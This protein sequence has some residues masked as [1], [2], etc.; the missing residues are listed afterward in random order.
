MMIGDMKQ[1]NCDCWDEMNKLLKSLKTLSPDAGIKTSM[2]NIIR[3]IDTMMDCDHI[4]LNLYDRVSRQFKPIAWR[5]TL[6]P[7]DVPLEQKFMGER[8]A[9]HEPVII[10]DLSP[11]NYRL[12]PA[13]ARLGLQSMVGVPILA[14]KKV[15]GTI[16]VFSR[17]PAHFREVEAELLAVY[18][19]SASLVIERAAKGD[20]IRWLSAENSLLRL[21]LQA[22]KISTVSLLYEL[23]DLFKTTV[24]ADGVLALGVEDSAGKIG[25]QEVMSHNFPDKAATRLKT[26]FNEDFLAKLVQIPDESPERY[27]IRHSPGNLGVS[28]TNAIFIIPVVWQRVLYG[29]IIFY[30]KQTAEE[31]GPERLETFVKQITEYIGLA[32]SRK[33]AYSNMQRISLT[34]NLT[35][36][37]N[38][39][40]FDY[41][42]E[43]EFKRVKR[44]G[45]SLSLLLIDID[46]F[47]NINDC[48]G[49]TAGDFI[50]EQISALLMSSIRG[51][52]IAARYGGE[53]LAVILPETERNDAMMIA[54]RFREAVTATEFVFHNQVLRITVSVG[55]AT[56]DDKTAQE[57]STANILVLAADQAL[58]RAKQLG[59]N[60]AI[61]WV[62]PEG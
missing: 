61:V 6:T 20:E 33:N 29:M 27:V 30:R 24:G 37:S 11:Y 3:E 12:R 8:Y 17:K 45:K 13:V 38:R 50:L 49:H 42:I 34:D 40:L 62:S 39:R 26:F 18:A 31:T 32:L 25:L 23:G 48:Y 28:G 22:E 46:H 44:S 53:E 7:G 54:E 58:Y 51:I 60:L 47:K 35:N 10:T 36:L 21:L 19:R 4:F 41:A 15:A 16:E 2:E 14:G 52:D 56:C 55:V 1:C 43:R 9:S 5:S 57:I 59:R